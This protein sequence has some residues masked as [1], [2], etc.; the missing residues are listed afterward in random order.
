MNSLNDHLHLLFCFRIDAQVR[1]IRKQAE[2][3]GESDERFEEGTRTAE[4][5][6][7]HARMSSDGYRGPEGIEGENPR[8]PGKSL[9]QI[10][11]KTNH[12]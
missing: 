6:I 12:L 10:I 3:R 8:D 11:G 9:G 1:R 2:W 5:R 4:E 7:Q